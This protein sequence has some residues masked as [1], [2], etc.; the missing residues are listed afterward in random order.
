MGKSDAGSA[1][2]SRIVPY[3]KGEEPEQRHA[4]RL[5]VNQE[6]LEEA[7]DFCRQNDIVMAVSNEGHHWR[8]KLPW[9]TV[10][11]WPSSAK[12][13]VDKKW[14]KGKHVHDVRQLLRELR[15]ILKAEHAK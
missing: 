1:G 7:K 13:V 10:D 8:F 5:R 11:W 4:R 3:I 2:R 15:W 14:C 6:L 9:H 12:M